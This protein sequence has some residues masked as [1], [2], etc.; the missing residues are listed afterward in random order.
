MPITLEQATQLNYGDMLYDDN[1]LNADGTKVRHRVNGQPKTWKRDPDRI[2]VSLKHG[3]Y[4]YG[5]LTNGTWEGNQY[6]LN[7]DMVSLEE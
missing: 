4:D 7:L 6:T 3:L 2:K 5:E 1:N